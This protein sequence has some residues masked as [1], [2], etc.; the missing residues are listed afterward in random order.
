MILVYHA[1]TS[2]DRPSDPSRLGHALPLRS[3]EEHL[4]WLM[5][6]RRIVTL[7]EYLALRARGGTA[8]RNR[9]AL[10]FDDGLAST[11]RSVCASLQARHLPATFFVSTS[12]LAPGRLL[13]FNYLNALCYQGNYDRVE[14]QGEALPLRSPEQRKKA[15]HSLVAR[16]R[17]SGDPR[18][19]SATMAEVYPLPPAATAD[20]EGMTKEQLFL[21]R[22][23]RLFELGA[24]TISHPYL[25]QLS[26]EEQATEVF[27]SKQVLSELTGRPVRYFAY[28]NGDYD[29]D[30]LRL[31]KQAG[32]EAAFATLSRRLGGEER[33]EIERVGIYSA[34]L[35]R[36]WLKAQGI[37]TMARRVGLAAG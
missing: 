13:W 26:P 34:S 32:Y 3:F 4:D 33:F 12:H 37:A 25:D 16:A 31:V 19:F 29:R 36:L 17:A 11:F 1:V 27:E 15:W 6:C 2:D 22:D 7:E 18:V 14:V 8:S 23:P 35:L 9:V 10:T 24:H 28:P 5:R 30:T 20:Y 21:F